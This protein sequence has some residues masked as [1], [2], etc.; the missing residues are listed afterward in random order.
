[1]R[2][3]LMIILVAAAAWSGYWYVGS[4]GATRAFETWFEDRRAEGWVADYAELTTRGF[5]NRFDTTFTEIALADPETGLA[6]E[7]PFFQLFALS[8][9]PNHIIAVWP[10]DQLLASPL[11]KYDITSDDLRASL[12]TRAT[13]QLPLDRLTLTGQALTLAAEGEDQ[14][15][16][17]GTLTLGAERLAGAD[18]GY[19]L[20]LRADGVAPALDWRVRIDPGGKLPETFEALQVDMAVTFDKPWD[21]SAIEDARPQPRRIDLRLAQATWGR[22]DLQAAGE[23]EV[24]AAGN[25]DGKIVI[26]ARNWREILRLAVESGALPA[27]FADTLEDG[28]SLVSQMAGNPKTLDIPL[29]LRNGT[30][31]LGP[32]PIGPAPVLRLR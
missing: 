20:G 3:L 12:V 9:R 1:M 23:V 22:L 27:G 5:P 21:L 29:T 28:L 25:P 8:Y 30:V 6:W 18:S 10:N 17:I 13:P 32:V 19:R 14:P 4:T 16:R 2:T 15:T 7:A 11:Q 26:K 24:D 31:R